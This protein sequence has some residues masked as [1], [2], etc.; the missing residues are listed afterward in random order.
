MSQPTH[1]SY[2]LRLWRD[3]AST[4]WR[5]TLIAVALPEEQRHFATLEALCAFLIA[6]ANPSSEP[7]DA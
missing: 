3:D 2:L 1:H 5:A 7:D 4:F 6:Q